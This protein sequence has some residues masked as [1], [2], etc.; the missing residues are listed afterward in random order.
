[1]TTC[2]RFR[3]ELLRRFPVGRPV[4]A[5]DALTWVREHFRDTLDAREHFESD[6]FEARANGKPHA[7]TVAL[8]LVNATIT[9]TAEAILA[10]AYALTGPDMAGTEAV[11]VDSLGI[12]TWLVI[13]P[14][15][16]VDTLRESCGIDDR[17]P[18][19][20]SAGGA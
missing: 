17:G 18:H 2:N 9:W 4:D 20:H 1:M 6:D 12:H 14:T 11:K 19:D 7:E 10:S 13:R 5:T 15:T 16:L 8:D 3:T